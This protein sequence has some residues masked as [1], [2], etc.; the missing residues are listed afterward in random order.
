M[1]SEDKTIVQ[2]NMPVERAE[3]YQD[4]KSLPIA[5]LTYHPDSDSLKIDF[6]M[7]R[8]FAESILRKFGVPVGK[9]VS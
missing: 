9:P 8:E 4:G 2:F 3:E 1:M 7:E 6:A 5:I